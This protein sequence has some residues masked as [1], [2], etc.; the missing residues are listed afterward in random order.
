[1]MNRKVIAILGLPGSGKSEVINYLIKKYGWPKVYFG[2]VTF[3]E[4][5]KRGL[6]INEKN[7][8]M[9]REDIRKKFGFDYYPKQVIKK[10]IK[11]KNAKIVLVESLYAWQE[12]LLLKN[13]F[14]DDLITIAVY[15]K[16]E[17]RYGRL[18]KRKKRPL[19]RKEAQ[20]RDYAQIENLFQG[21]PIAM[22]DYVIVNE[23]TKDNL[24]NNIE[25]I[26]N[27]SNK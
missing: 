24:K 22:A 16:P 6:E 23:G 14:K 26:I 10:I 12:F 27:Q 25:K 18:G 3:D 7:E 21:G 17:V 11:I 1:M 9:V 19:S 20:S 2:D 8:R 13:K 4:L 15:A 5:K